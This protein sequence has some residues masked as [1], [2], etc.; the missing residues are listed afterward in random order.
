MT[1]KKSKEDFTLFSRERGLPYLSLT[2]GKRG[3]ELLKRE[4]LSRK[5]RK[6]RE[7]EVLT[8]HY[9][10][11]KKERSYII[12]HPIWKEGAHPFF[13][14]LKKSRGT[15]GKKEKAAAT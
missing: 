6:G 7:K 5:G 3:R 14:V 15:F 1:K 13:L 10:S 2:R 9:N 11:V 8:T 4:L 12:R